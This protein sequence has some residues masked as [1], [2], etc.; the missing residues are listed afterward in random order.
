MNVTISRKPKHFFICLTLGICITLGTLINSQA[1]SSK[2]LRSTLI[3]NTIKDTFS[4]ITSVKNINE[5][6]VKKE[7][8]DS[9]SK[10]IVLQPKTEIRDENNVDYKEEALK[11]ARKRYNWS[12][13]KIA[14]KAA[15]AANIKYKAASVGNTV[16]IYYTNAGKA[17]KL[18]GVLTAIGEKGISIGSKNILMYNIDLSYQYLFSTRKRISEK[19]G[20]IRKSISK[21]NLRRKL[22]A[23]GL[24][25]KLIK[26][27]EKR[28]IKAGYLWYNEAWVSA[29]SIVDYLIKL[30][31]KSI[32]A[33]KHQQNNVE[34]KVDPLNKPKPKNYY[35]FMEES[36][37]YKQQVASENS[38]IDAITGY[39]FITWGSSLAKIYTLCMLEE[40]DTTKVEDKES[41]RWYPNKDRTQYVTFY[42]NANKMY[43]FIITRK[44]N[45]YAQL[46]NYATNVFAYY[47][48]PKIFPT[49]LSKPMIQQPRNIV[50]AVEEGKINEKFNNQQYAWSGSKINASFSI[51]AS[52]KI[53]FAYI[54]IEQKNH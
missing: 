21:Y 52:A 45:T 31:R 50:A 40:Y 25:K 1:G 32:L 47:S 2:R 41:F 35:K 48:Y 23:K 27:D 20:F 22:Y 26:N 13:E 10:F 28:N 7:V 49:Q 3:V 4:K 6:K 54:S 24:I 46:N 33:K 5:P 42:F 34:P 11:I 51:R 17:F 39:S 38:G 29:K 18:T 14:K 44:F 15:I 19:K 9:I 8:Y 36:N 16:T 30:E 43:K 12:N 53:F 37:T